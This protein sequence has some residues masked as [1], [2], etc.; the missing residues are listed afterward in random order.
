MSK[1]ALPV[2]LEV[3]A[4]CLVAARY[5]PRR[6]S[7]RSSLLRRARQRECLESEPPQLH[8]YSPV[9][10]NRRIS[11]GKPGHSLPSSRPPR[12]TSES[13]RPIA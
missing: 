3:S 5:E 4:R 9:S 8:E 11:A 12:R 1:N 10:A 13:R 2:A 7:C 6:I